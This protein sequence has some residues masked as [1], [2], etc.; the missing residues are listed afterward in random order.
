M[1]WIK[2]IE[3]LP[4]I[5]QLVV[6]KDEDGTVYQDICYTGWDKNITDYEWLDESGEGDAVDGW[7][8]IEDKL[9]EFSVLVWV[10]DPFA[11]IKQYTAALMPYSDP[12]TKGVFYS[13][14]CPA[15]NI[16]HWM[17]LPKPPIK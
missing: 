4:P 12:D 8:S 6:I 10:Y 7:I 3:E 1:K 9:P 5:K 14:M 11:I 2:A 17:P 13:G 15:F 16:T